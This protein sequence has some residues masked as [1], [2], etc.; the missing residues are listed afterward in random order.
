M[1]VIIASTCLIKLL[2][3]FE[4]LGISLASFE[5]IFLKNVLNSAAISF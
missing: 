3:D 4:G 1:S 2:N 5:S